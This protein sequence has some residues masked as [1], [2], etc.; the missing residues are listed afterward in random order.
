[1]NP[2]S[3]VEATLG[4]SL[5]EKIQS[6]KI[7]LVGSGGIGCELLKDLALSGFRHIAVIDLDTIDVSNLNRQFLFR[8]QHVGQPKCKVACQVSQNMVPLAKETAEYVAHHGNVCDNTQFNVQ[9]VSQFNLVL[10][11]LDNVTARRRVNRLCL[12]AKVPLIEAGTTGY[13]GQV[14][15]IDK[16]SNLECYECVTQEAQKVYPICTIRSTPSQPVH[17]I[18]WAK[19]LYKLLFAD[20][21]AD[22]ML[23]EGGGDE[24]STYMEAVDN[25]RKL[26]KEKQGKEEVTAAA[27]IILEK[28]FIDEIQK[29]LDMERYKTAQKTPTPLALDVIATTTSPPTQQESYKTTNVWS[30]E[31]CVAEFILCLVEAVD[32]PDLLPAFD[33][34]DPLAMKLV[35]A[36]CNLRSS[37]FSISPLQSEYSAKGIA[38][39]IIPAIA[40]TNA[41]CAGLQVLQA[42]HILQAQLEGR[43]DS[44]KERCR[45][46]DCVR[47]RS[48]RSG[49]YLLSSTLREP[50][51]KCFVCR[52]ASIS[53]TLD[54][55]K[56]TLAS[57][58][59][60]V[61]KEKLGFE[62]PSL[63]LEDDMVWEEG[64]DADT[65]S[66]L[67]NLGK[68]LSAL[69]CGGISHG[70]V[71]RVEDF[72]QDLEVDLC[73]TH[74]DQWDMEDG[75]D[76][77]EEKFFVGGEI[78]TAK[79]AAAAIATDNE[80]ADEDVDDVIDVVHP[81]NDKKPAADENGKRKSDFVQGMAVAKKLKLHDEDNVITIE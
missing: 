33:K 40:T 76:G 79:A 55:N 75:E 10:N 2:L 6:C 52:N 48:G 67:P 60:R 71:V 22:S 44:I 34:D 74:R 51:P 53:L 26:L 64:L 1:M 68:I 41:I 42:F 62:Q 21:Y 59:D 72:T 43:P 24:P 69:P 15:V 7:L 36:A 54:V 13:L 35:T 61:I 81:D 30:Q 11:A 39:N 78:P 28:L 17:C 70:T 3:G 27:R 18:V 73:I 46:I 19:E 12:A 8:S 65:E 32:A 57:L 9:Y 14:K 37:I 47:N 23:H 20:K 45:Y 56:W 31:D 38:G 49:L 77:T 5:V 25:Y 58:L 29:Q 16:A 63:M 4:K 80:H 50:N 66:Y